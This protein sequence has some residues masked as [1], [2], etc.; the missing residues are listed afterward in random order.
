MH[1]PRSVRDADV[2]GKRVLVRA[3][4][5][6]PLEDGDVADDTRIRASLPTLRD[7]LAR[8]AA[9]VAVCSHL[10]RPKGPDPAFG[11]APVAARL[12]KLLPD[13][14]I[15]VLEN[16]RF[17]LGETTNDPE[18][19][20]ATRRRNG[21]LRERRVRL[22]ASCA[23]VHRRRRTPAARVRRT[24][25]RARAGDARAAPGRRRA[26]VRS[27]RRRREGRRQDRR[28][29]EPRPTSGHGSRRW[30]DGRAAS[31]RQSA[32]VRRR[33]PDGRGR[34]RGLRARSREQSGAVRRSAR[35]LAR[36]RHRPGYARR[37]SGS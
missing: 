8:G 34:R 3:D 30:Q 15:E 12:G 22:G 17:D 36:S 28:A 7:L 19:C 5:N 4:L 11:M 16:T 13:D 25:P 33:A 31:R 24:A 35:R 6:V 18:T 29:R 9:H 21:S 37:A 23:R 10:G 14:R 32:A 20:A 26:P 2:A 1:R 27:R